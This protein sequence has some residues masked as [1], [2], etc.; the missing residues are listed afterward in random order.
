[1]NPAMIRHLELLGLQRSPFP[2]TPDTT[3]YFQTLALE[4]DLVEAGHCLRTR[5]GFVLL[6][7]EVGTGKTTFLRKLIAGLEQDGMVVSLVF[8]TFLQGG[9][10]LAAVLRDFALMPQGNPA[11]DI[12]T[13]NR[14]LLQC[15]Q[16]QTTCVLVID[17]AQNLDIESLELLR[18]LTCLESGQEKLLQI[19]LAG[20]PELLTLLAQPGI[21]QLTSRI[22]KH[23]CL[24]PLPA[25]SVRAYVQ[26]RLQ[27]A[28]GNDRFSLHEDAAAALYQATGG[29]PRH[30]HLIM[31]RCLYGLYADN[32]AQ[33]TIDATLVQ[34]AA[35]EAGVRQPRAKRRHAPSWAIAASLA[36][37]CGIATTTLLRSGDS[38]AEP[39]PAAAVAQVP[40]DHAWERCIAKIDP[41]VRVR[42]SVP[43]QT[44]ALLQT[45]GGRCLRSTGTQAEIAFGAPAMS[46][47]LDAVPGQIR[48]LQ[49]QLREAGHYDGHI[50]GRLGPL[51]HRAIARLQL[52]YHL[53]GTG[54]ADPLT[55]HL[56]DSL[57]S[58][59]SPSSNPTDIPPYGH[60]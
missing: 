16:R 5:A 38:H 53:P 14:F 13:L 45:H 15:W 35:A 27:A 17:D 47:P 42:Q 58:G 12:E 31:D 49:Q 33:R 24:D 41:A 7:G 6:T 60:G 2:P 51:T 1:M 11:A 25:G 30:I 10:L 43:A 48:H 46:Q 21:R 20:Q 18:L 50:D 55:L 57:P 19:V 39:A 59:A 34:A 40:Q 56:L 54:I 28:G 36:A 23:A 32:G 37:L 52:R 22:S 8:N 4:R 44:A 9:D 26:H 3:G 29:N